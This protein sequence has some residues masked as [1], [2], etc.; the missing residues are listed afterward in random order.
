MRVLAYFPVDQFQ[1]QKTV[2]N[3]A[4]IMDNTNEYF[5]IRIPDKTAAILMNAIKVNIE[6]EST[7]ILILGRLIS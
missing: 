2:P 3:E 7:F 6:Y 4:P 5:I 1:H